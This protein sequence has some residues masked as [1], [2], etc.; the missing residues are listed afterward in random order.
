[1][2][3]STSLTPTACPARDR[4]RLIFS[5]YR[6]RLPELVTTTVRSWNCNPDSRRACGRVHGFSIPYRTSRW[7][8]RGKAQRFDFSMCKHEFL[9]AT[10]CRSLRKPKMLRMILRHFDFGSMAGHSPLLCLV[11][12]ACVRKAQFAFGAEPGRLRRHWAASASKGFLAVV[13][14]Q[15][16]S[17]RLPVPALVVKIRSLLILFL[18]RKE[19]VSDM[20]PQAM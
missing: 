17:Y 8:C 12:N 14:D 13:G 18:N 2:P 10:F 6:H 9:R 15:R 7:R 4:L 11:K 16:R 5:L 3:W 1:M 19:T 20:L